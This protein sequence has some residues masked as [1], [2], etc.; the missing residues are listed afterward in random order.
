MNDTATTYIYT[1]SYTTLFRSTLN[2]KYKRALDEQGNF[3]VGPLNAQLTNELEQLVKLFPGVVTFDSA[4]GML[5]FNSDV[6]FA[7]GSAELTP[8]ARQA[9]ASV[10]RVLN[11]PAARG[12][13]FIVAGHTD[14]TPVNSA[15][16]K[17][18]GH[19]DNWYLSSH[20][21]IAVGSDLIGQ[22]IA[23]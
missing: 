14:S 15:T 4:T 16:A 13:E 18:A 11:A 7:K 9:I 2:E 23:S 3:K 19:K 6:T 12:Y 1:L 5:R 17:A 22:G 8:A 21:A 20:R 10:G